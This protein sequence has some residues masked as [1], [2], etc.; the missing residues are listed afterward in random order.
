MRKKKISQQEL[1]DLAGLTQGVVSRAANPT[2]G[3]LTLNTIIRIAAGFDVAFIGLF[4][5]FSKL[6]DFFDHL[7]ENHLADVATFSEEDAAMETADAPQHSHA[8]LRAQLVAVVNRQPT[9]S[10]TKRTRRLTTA[11]EDAQRQFVFGAPLQAVPVG[12]ASGETKTPPSSR[13]V[14]GAQPIPIPA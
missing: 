7:S 11:L 2:Y 12:G 4:V 1:A 5:P 8:E 14:S 9:E 6:V 13:V 10:S 3:K